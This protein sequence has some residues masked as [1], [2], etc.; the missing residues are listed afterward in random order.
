MRGKELPMMDSVTV[1][2][3]SRRTQSGVPTV[4]YKDVPILLPSAIMKWAWDNHR[5]KFNTHFLGSD[6][7]ASV[8]HFWKNTR[9]D[10]DL[11]WA[12]PAAQSVTNEVSR[13]QNES[14]MSAM[15]VVIPYGTHGD[16]VPITKQGAGQSSL[17]VVSGSSLTGRGGTIDTHIPIFVCPSNLQVK[18]KRTRGS[19]STDPMWKKLVWDLEENCATGRFTGRDEFGRGIDPNSPRGLL[20]GQRIAGGHRLQHMYNRADLDFHANELTL[21]HWSCKCPCMKCPAQKKVN[22]WTDMDAPWTKQCYTNLS[23]EAPE[24]PLFGASW[25]CPRMNAV[26]PAHTIAKGVA[27][28]A[29]GSLFK[30]L[31]YNKELAPRGTI[32]Q[33]VDVLNAML[34]VWYNDNNISARVRGIAIKDFVNPDRP[35]QEFPC[36][37]AGS[38]SKA[39]ALI[40]FGLHLCE[41]FLGS[42]IAE[43]RREVFRNLEQITGIIYTGPDH[44]PEEQWED[45]KDCI[46]RFWRHY[47]FLN[48]EARARKALNYHVVYKFHYLWHMGDEAKFINPRVGGCTFADEDF[49]GKMSTLTQGCLKGRAAID[50]IHGV[51]EQYRRALVM[52]WSA[53]SSAS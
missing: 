34:E 18:K 48:S 9:P 37:A 51:M 39:K 24:H 49:V 27:E 30:D 6:D 42:E 40:P 35:H 52:R 45:L 10:D 43:Q 21:P 32:T 13:S 26:D 36:Y 23:W 2:L 4:V 5:S 53:A 47:S 1:P 22:L 14:I 20:I 38:M 17:T 29:L 44:L 31:V 33:Q 19:Q 7:G 15:R 12:H 11:A 25:A 41:E 8:V 28:Y 16:A 50:V 3:L 46:H